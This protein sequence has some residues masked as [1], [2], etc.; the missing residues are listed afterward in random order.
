MYERSSHETG[1]NYLTVQL[2]RESDDE[3]GD[4]DLY[5]MFYGG[6]KV[7]AR[8]PPSLTQLLGRPWH[9]KDVKLG[10]CLQPKGLDRQTFPYDFRETSSSSHQSVVK[11]VSKADFSAS[12]FDHQ[13]ASCEQSSAA[14]RDIR[15]IL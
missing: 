1:W 2:D 3:T 12:G 11:K 13:G 5:G 6:A 10:L 15:R 4:P 14:R 7:G 9:T 8:H